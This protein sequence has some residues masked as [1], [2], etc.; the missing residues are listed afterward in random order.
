MESEDLS[1]TIKEMRDEYLG[2]IIDAH[3]PYGT[4]AAEWD[5]DGLKQDLAAATGFVLPITN[6]C[7]EPELDSEGLKF[8]L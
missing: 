1:D 4:G 2:G 3:I 8:Q 7:N 6:W 5:K